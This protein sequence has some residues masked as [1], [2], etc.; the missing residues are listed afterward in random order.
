MNNKNLYYTLNVSVLYLCAC[1]FYTYVHNLT[2]QIH[3]F[4]LSARK[5]LAL[6]GKVATY[7]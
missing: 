5:T 3:Y 2:K 7:Y 1:V 4:G 6:R